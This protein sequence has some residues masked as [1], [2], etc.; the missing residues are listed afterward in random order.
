ML[1]MVTQA[2]VEVS[3]TLELVITKLVLTVFADTRRN[4]GT[5][6]SVCEVT[7]MRLLAVTEV[8]ATVTA[9]ATKT[10]VPIFELAPVLTWRPFPKVLIRTF[11]VEAL[12]S[13]TYAVAVMF[14]DE[15]V[16]V[17]SLKV[18]AAS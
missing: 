6:P 9:P 13:P 3:A 10:A 15:R 14:V 12:T 4:P 16:F 11:P 5:P 17:A 8:F 18:K 2:T 1:S 7:K